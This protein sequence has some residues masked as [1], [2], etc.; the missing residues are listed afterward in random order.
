MPYGHY[1]RAVL[2]RVARTAALVIMAI[3]VLGA[4]RVGWVAYAPPP[5]ASAAADQTRF[6]RA[7]IDA[8]AGRRMQ[9]LFPEGDFFLTALTA[10]ATAGTT[11]DAAAVA[12][13]RRLR[14]HL[15]APESR[16]TFGSGMSPEHGVFQAGWT[17]T[18]A[19]DMAEASHQ[20]ED[21]R[22][23][24]RRAAVV[25]TALAASATGLLESYPGQF[26]PCDSVVA[27]AAL[28]RSARLLERP[29]WLEVVRRWRDSV[30]RFSDPVRGLLP[31]RVDAA[32]RA[33]EG[34]RGSS[35]AIVQAFWPDL[36]RALDGRVDRATYERFTAQFV[37]R[38]AG[39]VGVREY[40]LGQSGGGD[41]D[42]GPLL[43]GVSASASVVTLAAARAVGDPALASALNREAELLGLPL[44]WA[45]HRRYALGLVPVGDAFLAWAR[46]RPAAATSTDGEA[47]QPLWPAL[48]L[49]ALTPGLLAGGVWLLLVRASRR[50][51]DRT[52]P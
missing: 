39:L 7:A 28:S 29:D 22:D 15:D 34:P 21:R 26:W 52:P 38:R 51:G 20:A 33:L 14:D 23:V 41:V 8:G 25:A 42:S 3:S 45:G 10:S 40:P 37:V 46:T 32:G 35:Q 11:A 27:A 17:L 30:L 36:T 5:G 4:T 18:V 9:Q 6:L 43:L 31:H 47:P 2:S 16:T 12:D 1:T 19:V 50:P 48:V 44:S 13:L 24:E 49:A